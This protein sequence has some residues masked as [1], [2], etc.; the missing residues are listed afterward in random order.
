MAISTTENIDMVYNHTQDTDQFSDIQIPQDKEQD[1]LNLPEE[2]IEDSDDV[3][4]DIEEFRI[5]DVIISTDLDSDDSMQMYLHEIIQVPLLHVEEERH[6]GQLIARGKQEQQRAEHLHIQPRALLMGQAQR[7]KQH[8]I[9]ANLR[10]V[11]SIARTYLGQGLSMQDLVQEGN[12]GLIAATDKFDVTRG[13][14]FSTYATWAIRQ[15]IRRAI[16]NHA[17]IIRLPVHM[18][19]FKNR[20]KKTEYL[21]MQELGRE[22]TKE[23]LAKR[24][25]VDI[26]KIHETMRVSPDTISLELPIGE[27]AEHSLGE[28]VEDEALPGP[29][30]IVSQKLL[31]QQI[32]DMLQSLSERE[33]L[34]ISLRY[35]LGDNQSH[36]LEEVGK[37]L[38]VTRERVRQIEAQTMRKLR[39]LSLSEGLQAYLE[40]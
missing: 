32:K 25:E 19:E 12:T 16:A 14:R 10:L 7:A 28:L 38:H 30:E 33:R 11:I 15:A 40:E 34:V 37:E 31:K 9:E 5:K 20:M 23:E 22:P 27:E 21:L 13:Y 26:D 39:F 29:V 3:K 4:E 17:R 1:V 18:I 2:E 24:L 36:T 35:G 6:L 8:L